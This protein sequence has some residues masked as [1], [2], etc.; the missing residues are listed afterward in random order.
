MKN[1]V[2]ESEFC[3]AGKFIEISLPG[4]SC[5]KFHGNVS[6]K[7]YYMYIICT[8]YQ[9]DGFPDGFILLKYPDMN[10]ILPVL[11]TEKVRKFLTVSEIVYS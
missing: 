6:A 10:I 8:A 4:E 2:S 9:N 11:Q 5:E 7:V 1:E 3:Q